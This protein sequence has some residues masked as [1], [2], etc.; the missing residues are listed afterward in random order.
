MY[1]AKAF[2]AAHAHELDRFVLG[3]EADFGAGRALSLRVNVREEAMPAI[4]AMAAR[5]KALGI[6][7]DLTRKASGSADIGRLREVGV[8]VVDV[9]QDGSQYFDW[10]HTDNDTLD[11]I[12]PE[13]LAQNVAARATIIDFAANGDAVFGPIPLSK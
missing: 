11:K 13:T 2:A 7:L 10:H 4:T 1:G 5:L 12:D 8:P 6:E 9:A 3:N